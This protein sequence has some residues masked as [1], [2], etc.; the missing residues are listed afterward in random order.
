[1]GNLNQNVKAVE[2]FLDY[3][4]DT[5]I[6]ACLPSRLS[7]PVESCSLSVFS[8]LS[9]LTFFSLTAV[10]THSHSCLGSAFHSQ[11]EMLGGY[12]PGKPGSSEADRLRGPVR[13][14]GNGGHVT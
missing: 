5:L 13:I 2:F 11:V 10:D 3:D 8:I 14:S 1:L 12:T 9:L 4:Q 7:R 6:L